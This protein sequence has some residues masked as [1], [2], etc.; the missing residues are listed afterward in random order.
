[1]RFARTVWH[2]SRPQQARGLLRAGAGQTP[3]EAL[4]FAPGLTGLALIAQ[5]QFARE[6]AELS[7]QTARMRSDQGRIVQGAGVLPQAQLGWWHR[8]HPQ[9]CGMQ[10]L[11]GLCLAPGLQ[12][13]EPLF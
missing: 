7:L 10:N 5:D 12:G 2:Q 1:M 11:S 8:L 9:V 3:T 4:L 6:E 13:P